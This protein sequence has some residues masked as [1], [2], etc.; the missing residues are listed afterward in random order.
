[1]LDCASGRCAQRRASVAVRAGSALALLV[2]LS[3]RQPD[4]NLHPSLVTGTFPAGGSIQEMVLSPDGRRLYVASGRLV[5]GYI[6]VVRTT[7]NAVIASVAEGTWP[8]GLAITPDGAFVYAGYDPYLDDLSD[9]VW[10]MRT[11]DFAVVERVPVPHPVGALEVTPDGRALY[12][13]NSY[14][15]SVVVVRTE[16]NVVVDTIT[17][18]SSSTVLAVS[19]DGAHVYVGGHNL[20]HAI[21]SSDNVVADT[22]ALGSDVKGMT[23]LPDGSRLYVTAS[24]TRGVVY[25]VNLPGYLVKRVWVGPMLSEVVALPSSRFVYASSHVD[26]SVYVIRTSDDSLVERKPVGFVPGRMAVHPDGSR[27]YVADRDSGRVAIIGY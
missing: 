26:S 21:R 2:L 4:P 14:S 12:V 5:E 7:D 22:V 1:M 10:M 18:S 25:V 3:C 8:S 13:G 6:D 19:P 20:L 16:D 23:V 11:A 9:I 17:L 27:V 24:D 15:S